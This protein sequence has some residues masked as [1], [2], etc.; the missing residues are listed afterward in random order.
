MISL[1]PFQSGDTGGKIPAK[2]SRGEGGGGAGCR[3]WRL[4]F[5]RGS[6]EPRS[7][8]WAVRASRWLKIEGA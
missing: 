3:S 8:S 7:L 2:H 4:N 1:K 5:K 6:P